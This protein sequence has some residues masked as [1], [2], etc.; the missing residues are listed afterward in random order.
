MYVKYILTFNVW[1]LALLPLWNGSETATLLVLHY[2]RHQKIKIR[3]LYIFIYIGY[4]AY[5]LLPALY[6]IILKL[7]KRRDFGIHFC[8]VVFHRLLLLYDSRRIPIRF[9]SLHFVMLCNVGN[10]RKPRWDTACHLTY[11]Q[12]TSS[13]K[14]LLSEFWIHF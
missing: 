10:E 13:F 2:C 9:P 8:H 1:P 3:N 7:I 12:N 14:A 6:L 4:V 5:L 11:S